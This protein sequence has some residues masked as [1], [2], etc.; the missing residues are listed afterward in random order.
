MGAYILP[1]I[2]FLIAASL[3][4]QLHR[5]E[6]EEKKSSAHSYV[7][8]GLL[9]LVIITL[10]QLIASSDASNQFAVGSEGSGG[11]LL[12]A[13]IAFLII[14]TIG[15]WA[16]YVFLVA[17]AVASIL[18]A[19][20][21]TIRELLLLTRKSKNENK[22][23]L[24][25]DNNDL[26]INGLNAGG[27]KV[28]KLGKVNPVAEALSKTAKP[29]PK[30][31]SRPQANLPG[32]PMPM[33]SP[34]LPSRPKVDKTWLF[35]AVNLLDESNSAVDSGDIE[36][37]VAIIQKTLADFEIEVEMGEVNVGPTVTQY[38]LRPAEGVR[39]SAI[40]AL[41]N[42]LKL[43]LAAPSIRIE[44]P[45]PG[46]SL[47]G[48]EIPNKSTAMVRLRELFEM[49][50]FKNHPSALS[51][52]V[53]RDV[54]GKGIIED[55]AK[56][57]HLL[58]AGATGSGKSVCMNVVLTSFLMRNTP[59][60]VKFIIIDPKRVEM[61]LYNDIPHLITP[62]IIDHQKAANPLRWTVG[63][64]PHRYL[65]LP[66]AQKKNIGKKNE[67]APHK[68]SYLVVIV[69]ELAD[70]MSV[71]RNDVEATIVRLAQMA[72][73]VGIHLILATQRPSVD[74]IT[75]LIKAN[76]TSRIAF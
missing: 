13:T 34:S 23:K 50:E 52:V 75:G 65:L 29:L 63:K 46:K 4:K 19:F 47:V 25:R 30:F 59:E 18:I 41:Q 71:A 12:G 36:A 69:D 42:D 16:G 9:L 62:V 37:N 40:V 53:G 22:E 66:E 10:L 1:G 60:D 20:N 38:T 5:E 61:S 68:M 35:P 73:A 14:K 44:A 54:A 6:D 58:I 43:A 51:F 31:M 7:G 39:L 15:P 56:M 24:I 55:L 49:D 70:L 2:F 26:Q 64:R 57:P 27:F 72:R 67:P 17:G 33:K 76:I 32:R 28:K 45:I 74:I 11:G 8:V 21:L 48:V 3:Y